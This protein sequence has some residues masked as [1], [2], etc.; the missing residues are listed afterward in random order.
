[1]AKA[2]QVLN[3]KDLLAMPAKDYMN[4]AQ[5]EFFRNRLT[6]MREEIRANSEQTIEHIRGTE[7]MADPAD[8]ATV[9]EEYTLELRTRDRERK[10]LKKIEESLR[11]ISEGEYGYCIETG[12]PIGIAR[13]LARPTASLTVEAQERH[14]RKELQYGD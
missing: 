12:E 5:L 8:R 1:M 11:R 2:K 14:E 13:L 10:L 6:A 9:E 3:E 7:V 4:G